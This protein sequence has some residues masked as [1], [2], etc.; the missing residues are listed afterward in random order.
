MPSSA[1]VLLR[2]GSRGAE[3]QQSSAREPDHRVSEGRQESPLRRPLSA[4]NVALHVR[5][6]GQLSRS[7][8]SFGSVAD[9]LSQPFCKHQSPIF[10]KRDPHAEAIGNGVYERVKRETQSRQVIRE[11]RL[12]AG[13][14][15][16]A[17]VG[18]IY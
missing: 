9:R 17:E 13:A 16:E 18:G 12:D 5:A 7:V 10:T 2:Q 3:F 8:Q 1:P 15:Y 4:C 6:R 14:V 11:E